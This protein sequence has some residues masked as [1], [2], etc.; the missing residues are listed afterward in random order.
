MAIDI[1]VHVENCQAQG[2]QVVLGI[3]VCTTANGGKEVS[4]STVL[5]FAA[6]AVQINNAITTK[7]KQVLSDE[8]IVTSAQ[9]NVK[10]FG[11]AA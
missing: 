5:S 2:G 1:A 7:A 6:S 11:G 8:G 3:H 9:D 4:A 10:I